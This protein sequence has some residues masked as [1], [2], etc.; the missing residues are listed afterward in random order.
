[1]NRKLSTLLLG[2]TV[3]T[4]ALLAVEAGPVRA[5]SGEE[6]SA[7]AGSFK[8]PAKVPKN[9]KPTK[10]QREAAARRLQEKRAAALRDETANQSTTSGA[11]APGRAAP[12]NVEGGAK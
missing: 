1:M 5:D 8:N 9:R 2:L 12:Q 7:T 11:P 6:S 4:A 3:G 10:A